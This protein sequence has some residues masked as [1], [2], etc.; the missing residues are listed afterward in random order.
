M[1]RE[2][3]VLTRRDVADEIDIRATIPAIEA[4]FAEFE[5][6]GDLLP[7]KHIVHMPLGIAACIV[8]Y[9]RAT[10]LL[11]MKLGQERK[12][13]VERGLPTITGTLQLYDPDTGELLMIVESVLATMYRTGAAA[14]VAARHLARPDA[15]VLTVIGAGQLGQQCLRA[16]ATVRAFERIYLVDVRPD[17]VARVVAELAP[18]VGVPI[19][20][21]DPETACRKADVICTATNSTEPIVRSA[22]VRPGTHLSC[23]GADLHAKIECEMALLARCRLFADNTE[24]CLERGEV[25]QAVAAG[26]LPRDCFAGSLG[27]LINGD[28]AGRRSPAEI[29]LFDAVGL[30]VQDTTIA[31]SIY[32]QAVSKQL[33]LRVQFS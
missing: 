2:T 31:K 30:G 29:T 15:R 11:S 28:V 14:A 10:H 32:D 27:R 24:H 7:P 33:G 16:V 21:A 25:S 13:N 19:E 8:G 23:M 5:K 3:I 4:C 9:T 17:Q 6:G 12:S 26:V 18:R 20:A 22:W 1:V